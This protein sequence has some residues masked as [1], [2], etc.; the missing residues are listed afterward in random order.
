[1]ALFWVERVW[2]GVVLGSMIVVARATEIPGKAAYHPCIAMGRI[3][4]Y[5]LASQ[6]NLLR[7]GSANP[8][9]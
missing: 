6:Q 9:M 8:S 7:R 2:A 5:Y 4:S 1:M 3:T